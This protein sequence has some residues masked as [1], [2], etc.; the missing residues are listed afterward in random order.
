MQKKYFFFVG[1]FVCFLAVGWGYY[2]YQKP[3]AGIAQ[4]TADYSVTA[5]NLYA[6]YRSDEATAD[7]KYGN[8]AVEVSGVV[9]D[10]QTTAHAKNILLAAA[11]TGGVNCSF[12]NS[13]MDSIRVGERIKVK[14]KCTGFLMDVS[15]VDAVRVSN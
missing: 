3:R 2:Q 8:K 12:Q 7:K 9:A 10:V 11:A 1:A 15:L 14:G 4:A 6:E 5:E 13:K